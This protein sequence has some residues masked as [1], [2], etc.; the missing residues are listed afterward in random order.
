MPSPTTITSDPL[1]AQAMVV[2]EGMPHLAALIVLDPDA[3]LGLAKTLR[4]D[5]GDPASLQ[6]AALL[7]AVRDKIRGLLRSFPSHARV[8]ETWLTLEPWTIENGLITPTLKLK[9]AEIEQRFARE[10]R[11]LYAGHRVPA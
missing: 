7:Q 9:R 1:L 8:R 3:W 5:P 11:E 10:I 4:L 2:G 6:A